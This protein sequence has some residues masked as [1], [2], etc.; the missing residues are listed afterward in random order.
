[1]VELGVPKD[2]CKEILEF[3][4]TIRFAG[5]TDKFGKVTLSQYRKGAVAL[6]EEEESILSIIQSSIILGTRRT[7]QPRLG[8]IDYIAVIYEKVKLITIPLSNSSV[9]MLSCDKQADHD[10]IITE[11]ILPSLKK[12]HLRKG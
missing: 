11:K 3:D 2:L 8:E 7:L 4:N 1:M 5:I 10:S 12:H 9:L 6:L